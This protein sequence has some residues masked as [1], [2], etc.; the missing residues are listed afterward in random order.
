MSGRKRALGRREFLK[1]SAALAAGVASGWQPAGARGRSSRAGRGGKVIVIGF[2]GMDPFLTERMMDAG[3]L[4]ALSSLRAAGGYRRLGTSIPPQTPVA[5]SSFIV[6]A[7][8]GVHGIF[9]FIHRDPAQQYMPMFAAAGNS[10][11]S[12]YWE[13][14]E[15][16]LQ[17]PCWPFGHDPA[18][19]VI[20]RQ[21]TPFWDY[22]DGAGVSTH[23]YEIPSNYPAT[24]SQ[25]G[26]HRALAGLG[27][28]D[29][30]GTYG[31]Y[32]FFCEHG[33]AEPRPEAGGLRRGLTF[34]QD[35][36]RGR[37][38]GPTNTLLKNPAP[39]TVDF[40]V[41]RDLD[42]QSA[43]IDV[44][45]QR[46][47]LRRGQWSRW[48]RLKFRLRM[49]SFLP[50]EHQS[51]ICRFYLQ[52][53]GPRFRL[54]VTPI[55]IDPADPALPISEPPGFVRRI[56]DDLG[57]FYTAGFQ[58]DHKALSNGV[59][60]DEEYAAQADFVLQERRELLEYALR[61][62]DDGMLF[63]YFACTDLQPHMFWWD[64]EQ[65]HPVRDA[66]QARAGHE[67]VK[68]L[69]RKM[70]GIVADLLA[71][72]GETATLLVMSDHG[73]GN[74]RRQFNLCSWLRQEGYIHPGDATSLLGGVDWYRTRA[75]GLGLNSLY[76]NLRGRERDGIVE[77]GPQREALLDEL[78]AKLEAV[79]DQDGAPVIR[80]VYRAEQVYRG[81]QAASAPDLIVGYHRD[82]RV[83]WG[84]VLGEM[85]KSVLADNN[86]AWC[87]DHCQ[88][89]EDVPGV[90]FANRPL[91]AEGP[92]LEDL[93][94][95]ILA[96]FGVAAP[97]EMVGRSILS[98]PAP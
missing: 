47:L 75:Y 35:T 45:G 46:L 82:Y 4:P 6:G 32:Q 67:R 76:L 11:G 14:G 52:E 12:G 68:E 8:P 48:V 5:F 41:H 90:V 92:Q 17:I 22:L 24:P 91:A 9:D 80:K 63:F 56:A 50:D 79:R 27:T 72:Y 21:G 57:R 60:T 61:H 84:S 83:S 81:P 2:D 86:S 34:Q 54:Y 42:A 88:A 13:V 1:T 49:P 26:H 33:P 23:V 66:E 59:F 31:T 73:M 37:I 87:A 96:Q 36:A 38:T 62:Y 97:P 85:G 93:A 28:P 65:K 43:V 44:Q 20:F 19:P 74:F 16:K 40:A 25:H 15:H 71:R 10:R 89:A 77:P 3:E 94:P 69:Y 51:G 55:N 58:E 64:S 70:D 7:G 29:M 30:L 53:V 39:T 98:P 95:T 78:A 18:R